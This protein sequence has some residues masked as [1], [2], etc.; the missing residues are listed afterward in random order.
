M[1]RVILSPG[2]WRQLTRTAQFLFFDMR[3]ELAQVS[4]PTLV[5]V[6]EDDIITT[7]NQA[8]VLADV[9][10]DARLHVF[11]ETGHNPFVEETEAFIRIVADFLAETR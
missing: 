9:L 3:R 11:P 1:D 7:P 8:Q 2:P 4:A 5:L 10:P 6:G